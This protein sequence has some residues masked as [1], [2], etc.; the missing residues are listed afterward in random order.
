MNN[1]DKQV[2][3]HCIRSD[4]YSPKFYCYKYDN[5]RVIP[6]AKECFES[7]VIPIS[8][9]QPEQSHPTLLLQHLQDKISVQLVKEE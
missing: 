3:Y 9:A 1:P 7:I 8:N 4:Y 6:R 5:T 2:Y